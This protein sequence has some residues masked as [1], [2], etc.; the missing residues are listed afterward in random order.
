MEIAIGVI[1]A[2]A[3]AVEVFF[4]IRKANRA[5]QE[6]DLSQHETFGRLAGAERLERM[7]SGGPSGAVGA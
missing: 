6:F 4:L 7:E 2:V 1:L 3:V 5:V